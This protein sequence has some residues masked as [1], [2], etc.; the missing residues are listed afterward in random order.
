MSAVHQPF[1]G[2]TGE[3]PGALG[4]LGY[5]GLAEEHAVFRVQAQSQPA[6]GD[7]VN[8]LLKVFAVGGG[9]EG[10]EIGYEIKTEVFFGQGDGGLVHAKI[11]ADVRIAGGFNTG[12]RNWFHNALLIKQ[13]RQL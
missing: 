9:G 7:L 12:Q 5:V 8:Q 13:V 4:D 1:A 3:D 6:G 2:Q 10:V 11:V